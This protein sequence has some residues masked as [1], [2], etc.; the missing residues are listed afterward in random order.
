MQYNRKIVQ[1]EEH[2]NGDVGSIPTYANIK[3][4]KFTRR[5]KMNTE[6]MTVHK[7]LAELK[8]LGS[9]IDSAIM[10]GDFV[11]TKKNNQEKVSGK[12]VDKFKSDAKDS[13]QKASDLIRRRNA[14][15]DALNV[16][17]ATTKVKIGEA[18]YTVVEAIDKKNHGMDYYKSLR[19]RLIQQ[20]TKAKTDCEKHNSAL[21]DKGEQFVAGM[22]GNRDVKTNGAEFDEAVNIYIKSNSMEMI[23]PLSIESK[24]EELDNMI[25]AFL[26]EVDAALSVSNALTTI[27]IEY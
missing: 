7:A 13:Y 25:N 18:E 9:R 8:V 5:S 12:T 2:R 21:Q 17:N 6:T 14:I 3:N 27:T 11:K 1:S 22:M 20:Y 19:D 10:N 23:D 4:L 16:S 24:I 15:K 26:T